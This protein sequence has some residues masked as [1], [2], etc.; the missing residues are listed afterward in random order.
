MLAYH[1]Y[2]DERLLSY[3]LENVGKKSDIGLIFMYIWSKLFLISLNIYVFFILIILFLLI[4][5][6]WLSFFF[7]K[8]IIRKYQQCYWP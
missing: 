8:K 6:E 3:M 5:S 7:K 2:I 1:R 4:S